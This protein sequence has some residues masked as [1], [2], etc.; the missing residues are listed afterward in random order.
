MQSENLDYILFQ[1][2]EKKYYKMINMN[3]ETCH[4]L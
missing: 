4:R 2:T 1:E 3:Y